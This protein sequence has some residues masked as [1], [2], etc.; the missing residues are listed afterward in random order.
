MLL[1]GGKVKFQQ[2]LFIFLSSFA[3]K[4]KAF[5]CAPSGKIVLIEEKLF[6]WHHSQQE[7][8]EKVKKNANILTSINI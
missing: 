5:L 6:L 4:G 1:L 2:M 7:N 8:K 3:S